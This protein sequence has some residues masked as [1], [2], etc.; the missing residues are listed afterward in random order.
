MTT[1]AKAKE[2]GGEY[3][4]P[5]S[6]PQEVLDRTRHCPRAFAC[7]SPGGSATC[8]VIR[9]NGKDVLFIDVAAPPDC[10]YALN[11]GTGAMCRCPTHF[12]LRGGAVPGRRPGGSGA[13]RAQRARRLFP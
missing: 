4:M 11:W 13:A 3:T 12:H 2:G 6:V 1:L 9:A 5:D 8:K 10:P 7:L